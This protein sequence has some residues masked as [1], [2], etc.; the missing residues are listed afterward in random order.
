MPEA[1]RAEQ[2]SCSFQAQSGGRSGSYWAPTG[3]EPT[4]RETHLGEERVRGVPSKVTQ[5]ELASETI[6][7]L[8]F[9]ADLTRASLHRGKQEGWGHRGSRAG[10][11]LH[12]TVRLGGSKGAP[13]YSQ[14]PL[15]LTHLY[16]LV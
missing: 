1:L 16:P 8:A 6:L 2:Q 3:P 5:G 12:L 14:L 13:G 11:T 15:F 9:Q 7:F 4:P 10:V